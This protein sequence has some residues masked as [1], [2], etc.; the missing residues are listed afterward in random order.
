[1][2][3][4]LLESVFPQD[5]NPQGN[6]FGGQLV[7]WMDKAA[8]VAAMR[9]ARRAV[10]TAKIESIEFKVPVHV[11]NLVTLDAR[12]ASVGRTSMVVQ[13]VVTREGVYGTD[14]ELTTTGRFTMVAVDAD[15]RPTPVLPLDPAAVAAMP[16]SAV[17]RPDE[18]PPVDPGPPAS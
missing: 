10:V 9:H 3:A 5:T 17:E 8:G 15:G 4:V 16:P 13:V 12:V 1:M 18:P 11:G 14:N 2:H 7:A 6:L